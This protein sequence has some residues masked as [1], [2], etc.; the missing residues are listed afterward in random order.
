MNYQ[1]LITAI[2]QTVIIPL[3]AVLTGYAVKWIKAKAAEI[4]ATTD[5]IYAHKYIDMLQE[6]IIDTVIA[7]NQTY[8]DSLKQS[9]NFDADA[10]IR[11]FEMV[12]EKV[13]ASLTEEALEYLNSA[14]GDLQG[15][16]A[17][18]IEAAVREYK[19]T[20]LPSSENDGEEFKEE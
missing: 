4:K 11:A 14:I 5:N 7:V 10:Q 6:T 9:G 1:E 12:K 15:Y 18:Q 3:L 8:V 2:F 17:T 19:I 20:V 13:L 16:I